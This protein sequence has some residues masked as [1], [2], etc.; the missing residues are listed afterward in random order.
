[1]FPLFRVHFYEKGSVSITWHKMQ[2]YL[3]MISY[4]AF[5]TSSFLKAYSAVESLGNMFTTFIWLVMEASPLY[6]ILMVMRV[7]PQVMRYPYLE[8]RKAPCNRLEYQEQ[9]AFAK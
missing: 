8:K 9:G 7:N 2:G 3:F 6:F 5:P 4:R 1:M